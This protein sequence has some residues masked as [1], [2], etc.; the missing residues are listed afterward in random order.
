MWFVAFGLG[1]YAGLM[2]AS[3]NF[4]YIGFIWPLTAENRGLFLFLAISVIAPVVEESV[5]PAGLYLLKL[6]RARIKTREWIVLGAVAG[7]GFGLLENA[8]YAT[9]ALSHGI[10]A[11][12]GVLALRTGL[13]LP[14][15]MAATS[16]AAF[17]VMRWRKTG[18]IEELLKFL[19]VA[20]SIHSVY[21]LLVAVAGGW[22]P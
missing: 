9:E 13:S 2:A 10:H 19:L 18:R 16:I 17:G 21:N 1:A 3:Y 14:V 8:I 5:K 7:L 6:T 4:Q 15:H 12:L 22:L 11:V 20:I